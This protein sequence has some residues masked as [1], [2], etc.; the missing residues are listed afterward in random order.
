MCIVPVQCLDNIFTYYSF[1]SSPFL[2]F[3]LL[4]CKSLSHCH[5]ALVV[6]LQQQSV[7]AEQLVHMSPAELATIEAEAVR[8][9]QCR[10][11]MDSRRSDWLEA[12]RREIQ[13]DVGV[14]PDNVWIYAHDEDGGSDPDADAADI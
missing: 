10:D 1:V 3:T 11:D 13:I 8:Q 9:K 5:Q 4:P 14:D 2:L 12:N 7:S 6:A